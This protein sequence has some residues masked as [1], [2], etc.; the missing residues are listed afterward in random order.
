MYSIRTTNLILVDH[1]IGGDRSYHRPN[2][3]QNAFRQLLQS[4]KTGCYFV[5]LQRKDCS[6]PQLSKGRRMVC[7]YT[8][9][10]LIMAV[11]SVI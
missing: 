10:K 7:A 11:K 4:S 5:S 2:Q 1:L 8:H 6:A 3:T 9:Q